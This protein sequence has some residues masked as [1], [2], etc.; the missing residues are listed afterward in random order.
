M[1]IAC[2]EPGDAERL[3]AAA[4]ASTTRYSVSDQLSAMLPIALP[5]TLR[6][7]RQARFPQGFPVERF[8]PSTSSGRSSPGDEPGGR[9]STACR[10]YSEHVTSLRTPG[11]LRSRA[12]RGTAAIFEVLRWDSAACS[13]TTRTGTSSGCPSDA[14]LPAPARAGRCALQRPARPLSARRPAAPGVV[15]VNV[16]P[17]VAQSDR[18]L[19]RPGA[20]PRA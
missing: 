4:A 18:R 15:Y 13:A 14:R 2:N 11:G 12:S 16:Q 20:P 7:G 17:A 3:A 9:A 5:P 8:S 6:S 10:T 1:L 19:P